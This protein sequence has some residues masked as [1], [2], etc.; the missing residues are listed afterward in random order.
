MNGL[1]HLLIGYVFGL[2]FLKIYNAQNPAVFIIFV[3]LAALMPDIDNSKSTV[4]NKIKI[5]GWLFKHR[6]FFHTL[7]A[8]LMFS[9]LAYAFS[10]EIAIAVLVG[11]TSHL[12]SDS[13]TP[14]GVRPLWPIS[15]KKL[16]LVK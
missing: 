10:K 13:L 16:K 7:W 4:G 2:L 9:V 5:I 15:K 11:Y 3:G 1:T 14:M 8:A 6:G 12:L